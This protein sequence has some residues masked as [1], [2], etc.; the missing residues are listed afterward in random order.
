MQ[1]IQSNRMPPCYI[2][3]TEFHW[4]AGCGLS[5]NFNQWSWALQLNLYH[6]I[7]EDMT[8]HPPT[9]SHPNRTTLTQ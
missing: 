1:L 7:T 2:S 8:F 9:K 5:H 6:S 4:H 3:V